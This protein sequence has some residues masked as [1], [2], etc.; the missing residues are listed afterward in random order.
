MEK[1][2][3]RMEITNS[4]H[5]HEGTFH[6]RIIACVLL[7]VSGIIRSRHGTHKTQLIL[8]Y[9]MVYGVYGTVRVSYYGTL[10]TIYIWYIYI[11]IIWNEDNKR[12]KVRNGD[13]LVISRNKHKAA[14]TPTHSVS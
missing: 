2:L 8:P 13:D 6:T 1:S 3:Q 14:K 11:C 12:R 4:P 9:I 10:S 5:D 7:A